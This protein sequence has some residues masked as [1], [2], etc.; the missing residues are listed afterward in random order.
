MSTTDVGVL[1]LRKSIVYDSL[2]EKMLMLAERG[3]VVVSGEIAESAA[4]IFFIATSFMQV[5]RPGKPIWV[6]MNT[7]GG[8]ATECFAI[9]DLMKAITKQG[10]AINIV[11]VGL[12]ASAGAAL[13]QMGTKRYSLPH[14]QFLIHQASRQTD[15]EME[16]LSQGEDRI[17]ELKRKNKIFLSFISER[18]GMPLDKVIELAKKTDYWLDAEAA[19]QFGPYGLI[20]EIVD[21]YPFNLTA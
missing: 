15:A 3:I 12:I 6:M 10:I 2:D 7:P 18:T 4:S 20:D 13:M 8:S 1:G 9:C 17:Q 11:G 16:E 14:T 21:E 5:T 19:K